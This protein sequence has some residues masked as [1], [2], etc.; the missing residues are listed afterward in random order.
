MVSVIY[1]GY[2]AKKK[3]NKKALNFAA[4]ISQFQILPT[5]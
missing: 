1:Q 2:F 4:M 3:I 5:L